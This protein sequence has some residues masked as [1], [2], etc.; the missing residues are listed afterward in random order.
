MNQSRR[1]FLAKL[2]ALPLAAKAVLAKITVGPVVRP[3]DYDN[4]KNKRILVPLG[5]ETGC[6]LTRMTETR[7]TPP[8]FEAFANSETDLA[9]L[10]KERS[11]R[12]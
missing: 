7:L 1:S 9:Q 4:T 6:T 8:D 11:R 2:I 3:S 12:A 5:K 10:L